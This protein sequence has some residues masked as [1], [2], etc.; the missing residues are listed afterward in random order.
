MPVVPLAAPG[1]AVATFWFD[2]RD[3]RALTQAGYAARL[4]LPAIAPRAPR[5]A[6]RG[7]ANLGMRKTFT[8]QDLPDIP[9]AL[10]TRAD[11]VIE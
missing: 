3:V 6:V 1:I 7:P 8:D 4:T 11:E 2:M 10:L 5:R 9:A